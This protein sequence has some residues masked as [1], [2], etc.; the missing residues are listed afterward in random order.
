MR[1]L[2]RASPFVADAVLGENHEDLKAGLDTET[3]PL[4]TA[5]LLH[6]P[7]SGPT[8]FIRALLLC[9]NADCFVVV[10]VALLGKWQEDKEE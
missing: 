7:A 4:G 2:G 10:V 1:T 3:E 6:T 9:L 5:L 8:Y